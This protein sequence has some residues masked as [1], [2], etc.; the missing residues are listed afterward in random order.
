[1]QNAKNTNINIRILKKIVILKETTQKKI[2]E[3]KQTNKIK[4][5]CF[6]WRRDKELVS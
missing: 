5:N 2:K 3:I 1:M 6:L 4:Q